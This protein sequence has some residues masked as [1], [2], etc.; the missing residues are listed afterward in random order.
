MMIERR[1]RA[2][3][4]AELQQMMALMFSREGL[5]QSLALKL[6]PSDVVITPFGK[7][8]TTW[9]QQIVHTL[10]TQGDMDFDDISRVVPWIET[11]AALGMDLDAP[12]RAEPRA[13]KSHL[14]AHT[15][16]KGGRY[17]NVVRNPADVFVSLFKFQEGWFIEPGAIDINEFVQVQL[18]RSDNYFTH[19]LS[20]WARRNDSDVL[21]LAY[22]KML[23]DA[24]ATIAR[25]AAFIEIPLDDALLDLCEKHS[26]LA[27][28]LAH[29]DRFDD[30]MMRKLSEEVVGLPP[31]S[32]SSKVREG[33][34]GGGQT[35]NAESLQLIEECWRRRVTAELGFANYAELLA[36]LD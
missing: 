18:Q 22:E 4:L 6:R 16:P 8:G 19:L 23:K 1:G 13:F 27:F 15:V 11:S 20:W 3:N 10:R 9:T 2:Q 12:Q 28:M 32:D 17:I 21:F 26:S 24:R 14:D 35:L 31:G 7:S 25:I 29:K 30:A 36:E 34:A 33:K 5:M